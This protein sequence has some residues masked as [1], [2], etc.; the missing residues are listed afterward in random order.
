[1]ILMR[2][3]RPNRSNPKKLCGSSARLC[4][5]SVP[6]A[7][8]ACFFL[9]G[10]LGCDLVMPG[11]PRQETEPS[12]ATVIVFPKQVTLGPQEAH[13][14][15]ADVRDDRGE[16]VSSRVY[17]LA[18]GGVIDDEGRFVAGN[19]PGR[20]RVVVAADARSADTATVTI[21]SPSPPDAPSTWI[22]PGQDIQAAVDVHPAGTAFLIKAGTH[23]LQQVVPKRGNEF[24][25]EPGAILSGAVVLTE[26]ERKDGLWVATGQSQQNPRYGPNV[27][28]SE[29]C[30]SGRKGCIYPED[31]FVNDVP[32]QQVVSRS[33]VGPGT[34][35]FDYEADKIYMGDDPTGRVVETS[36]TEFAFRGNH[37][38]GFT[39]RGVVIEKY[40]NAAQ[41]SAI[42]AFNSDD[43]VFEDNEIRLNH[44]KGIS[45]MGGANGR[46]AR[47]YVHHQGQLGVGTFGTTN[48]VIEGNEIAHNGFA[49]YSMFWEAG[50]SK[51]VRTEDL[52]V[53]D[54][55]VHH[56]VG[57]G[58]WTD[59]DNIRTLYE[60]NLT[61]ANVRMGIYHEISYDAVIRNNTSLEN[62]EGGIVVAHSPNVEV[63][64]NTVTDNENGI[65]GVQRDRGDGRYGPYQIRNLYVHD[66]TVSMAEGFTGLRQYVGDNSYFTTRNNRF[67]RNTYLLG[68]EPKYFH[69]ENNGRT[70]DE[71]RSYGHDVNGTFRS[72]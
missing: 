20:F 38:H 15:R 11:T 10:L 71:W 64:G 41:M 16:S 56:N 48:L 28:G 45:I 32:L 40:A 19:E 50:G 54:N 29:V 25:G 69:W 63:Y 72:R 53:R 1:M 36:T 34:W 30:K 47:N 6:V 7:P 9:T 22:Y 23:R 62:G 49:G 5:P 65:M 35:Y 70:A 24:V 13:T 51:F 4:T 42:E 8:A 18:T 33:E 58:L 43:V 12:A 61:V 55:Y 26:F 2:H 27:F 68:A 59:I 44:G 17:W 66:N 60:D 31:L 67:E 57:P 21:S 37:V 52:I 39:V 3:S 14:F 46:I